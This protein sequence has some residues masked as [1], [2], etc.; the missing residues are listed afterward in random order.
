M[1]I[2]GELSDVLLCAFDAR[3]RLLK[4][5]GE[6]GQSLVVH[7]APPTVTV[8]GAPGGGR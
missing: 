2:P 1:E 5:M 7:L 3:R 6:G 8:T 4:R